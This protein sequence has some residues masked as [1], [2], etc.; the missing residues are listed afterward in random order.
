MVGGLQQLFAQLSVGLD[1]LCLFF[2]ITS[3]GKSSLVILNKI[4]YAPSSVSFPFSVKLALSVNTLPPY[5]GHLRLGGV[6][7]S[8]LSGMPYPLLSPRAWAWHTYHTAHT[9][10]GRGESCNLKGLSLAW[11]PGPPQGRPHRVLRAPA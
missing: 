11:S 6:T 1:L 5:T 2:N 8:P 3:S 4:T 9:D 10:S 7:V